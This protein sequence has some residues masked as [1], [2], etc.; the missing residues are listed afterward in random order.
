MLLIKELKDILQN[1]RHQ[2]ALPL[3]LGCFLFFGFVFAQD[4]WKTS[5]PP[6]DGDPREYWE[7]STQLKVSGRFEYPSFASYYNLFPK[8][9]FHL[10]GFRDQPISCTIRFPGYPAVLAVARFI[11]NDPRIAIFINFFC[12][13]GICLFGISLGR[14]LLP[15]EKYRMIYNTLLCLSPS[16]LIA[17]G[18]GIDMLSG[19]FLVGGSL[20]LFKLLDKN[21][22][23]TL[24]W[25]AV[26]FNI[27][28]VLTRGNLIP[29]VL[30][31]LLS[32]MVLAF[33]R[34]SCSAF[35]RLS[36]V[37]ISVLLCLWV[38]SGRNETLTG[39]R[40]IST[41]GG[42]I[43]FHVLLDNQRSSEIQF[44][45]GE[46]RIILF[47]KAAREGRSFNEAEAL[48][49]HTLGSIVKNKVLND[50]AHFLNIMQ[51]RLRTFFLFS[52]ADIPRILFPSGYDKISSM[53]FQAF[54]IYK[55]LILAAFLLAPLAVWC[56][57]KDQQ[58]ERFE[59]FLC[60]LVAVAGGVLV[61]T[62]FTGAAGD[63]MRLPYNS[64][65]IIFVVFC[66]EMIMTRVGKY[67]SK[68]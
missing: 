38:W 40:I 1:L 68:T 33:S 47:A 60:L 4:F 28:A 32:L 67:G 5:T 39:R 10:T 45:D 58:Q 34:R 2:K 27:G 51:G 53:L 43:L 61:T 3:L 18:I 25:L 20:F 46:G 48:L 37:L 63:R 23:Y 59:L 31:L 16:Y 44:W 52:Y 17:S 11:W 14:L 13:L 62:V 66:L 12:Y 35:I 65:N 6:S 49:D 36:I 42:A 50:P 9:D 41:Q 30:I 26:L 55:W 8:E 54:R 19:F 29:F 22:R 21:A 15:S 56:L 64:F 57:R 24:V 7:L